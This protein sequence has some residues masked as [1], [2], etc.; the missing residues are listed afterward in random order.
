MERIKAR[1]KSILAALSAL[2]ET[3][4]LMAADDFCNPNVLRDSVIKR[5]ECCADTFWK[6]LKDYLEIKFNF[7]TEIARPKIIF[8]ECRSLG[9]ISAEEYNLC[10]QIT[11]D[12]NITA[13]TYNQALAEEI[14]SHIPTYF[15][16]MK[17]V[18]QRLELP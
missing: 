17:T 3:L 8:K 12:R 5:F 7:H 16:L 2:E 18:V 14:N 15:K 13:H 11:E 1:K 6:F 4:T 9:I 10:E